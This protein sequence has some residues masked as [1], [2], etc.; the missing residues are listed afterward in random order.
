MIVNLLFFFSWCPWFLLAHYGGQFS[1][2]ILILLVQWPT[3]R[4]HMSSQL[5]FWLQWYLQVLFLMVVSGI[6]PWGPPAWFLLTSVSCLRHLQAS[7][8][9]EP[10]Q[11]GFYRAIFFVV[12]ILSTLHSSLF[13]VT[14]NL[15]KNL[16]PIFS[17]L[18]WLR[19]HK[20]DECKVLTKRNGLI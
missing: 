7:N 19:L 6:L 3:S 18:L 20:F 13:F 8:L 15:L 5:S 16:G 12:A 1:T 2:S 9:N 14:I 10:C 11:L 17:L 4:Q